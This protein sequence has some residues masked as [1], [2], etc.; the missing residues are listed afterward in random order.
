MLAGK[1]YFSFIDGYSGYNQIQIAEE[2]RENTTFTC[3]WGTYAYKVLPFGLC[4]AP[5]T[6]QRAVLAIF[7]DL[8]HDCVEVYMGGFTVYGDDFSQALEN[9]VKVL[10]RCQEANL[11]LSSDKCRIMQTKGIVLGHH[12][13]FERIQVDPAK[14]EVISRIPIL[15]SQKEVRIF[16]GYAGYYRRFTENFT[17]IAAPLFNLLT[18]DDDF[19]WNVDCQQA[20]QVSMPTLVPDEFPDEAL[21]SISTITPWF[22]DV[23]NYLASG[24]LPQNMSARERHNIVQH[25]ANYSWIEGD[26]FYTGPDL[27]MRAHLPNVN[28][29]KYIL[30]CTDYVTKWVEAKALYTATEKVVVEF[31]FEDIFTRFGV[32][33]EIVTD[34]GTQFTS[35]LGKALIEQYQVKNL[36]STSY[37]AQANGQV[38]STNKVLESILTKTIHLHHRDW[39]EK[40][41]E[42]LWAYRITWRNVTRHTPYELVYGK[43]V[44]LP[45][46]F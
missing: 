44:L 7:S 46:K 35:K 36:K 13:S 43:Q 4:N 45:I 8:I 20:F 24:K 19:V 2:D 26:L 41:P 32:P 6:F 3:P 14:I 30:V 29:K 17:R 37:H 15:S 42:A 25:S 11:A 27:I 10:I 38:E 33:Q 16:L 18:K 23:A 39:A 31:L 12:V 40:L 34:Q 9:L 1:K 5:F 28:K 22:A 21:F